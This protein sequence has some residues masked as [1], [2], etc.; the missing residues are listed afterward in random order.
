[1]KQVI[2]VLLVS[3]ML[4][5]GAAHASPLDDARSAGQIV[6]LASGYVQATSSAPAATKALA[7]DVNKKRKAA[8]AKIAKKNGVT[9]EQVAAESYRKRTGG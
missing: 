3:M 5:A 1:M 4:A 8:Y 7:A 2:R 9:V 6:E